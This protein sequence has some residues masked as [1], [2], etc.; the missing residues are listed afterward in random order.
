MKWLKISEVSERE[1]SWVWRGYIPRGKLTH[2]HGEFNTGKTSLTLAVIAAV[3]G[4]HP[5]PGRSS[6][7]EP[8]PVLLQM[9]GDTLCDVV[10]PR[11]TK[12]GA[13]CDLIH[14]FPFAPRRED[15]ADIDDIKD[16]IYE[17]GAQ[18]FVLDPCDCYFRGAGVEE[19]FSCVRDF[20]YLAASTNCAVVLVGDE[21]PHSVQEIL[22]SLLIV[23]VEDGED[24]Y[25]R[26]LSHMT[27]ILGGNIDDYSDDVLFRI[28][29]EEGC[30]WVERS[31]K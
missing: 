7:C 6:P 30:Q 11:L 4:G 12:C 23:G 2:I 27:P 26:G 21:L 22:H 18:L 28:H 3:T 5:L 17:T 20:S 9:P 10:K 1:I 8:I 14:L 25:L 13:N 16:A 29:P 24:K 19:I 31:D 15:H